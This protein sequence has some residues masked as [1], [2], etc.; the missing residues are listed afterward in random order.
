MLVWL[1]TLLKHMLGFCT[2]VLEDQVASP[3]SVGQKAFQA[4]PAMVFTVQTFLAEMVATEELV[5]ARNGQDPSFLQA[6]GTQLQHK[7]DHMAALSH[8]DAVVLFQALANS[9]L[10]EEVTTTLTKTVETKLIQGGGNQASKTTMQAQELE[11]LQNYLTPSDWAKLED[12]TMF[13]GVDTVVARLRSLGCTNAKECTKKATVGLLLA[14]HLQKSPKMPPYSTIYELSNHFGQMLSSSTV[15]V[16]DGVPSLQVYPQHPSAL[17]QSML[18]KIYGAE[19]PEARL[20]ERLPLLLAHHIPVRSSSK[21]LKGTMYDPSAKNQQPKLQEL[22]QPQLQLAQLQQPQLQLAQL[23]HPAAAPTAGDHSAELPTGTCQLR[24]STSLAA[25]FAAVGQPDTT[26]AE[27]ARA[28]T[29]RLTLASNC[30]CSR[31]KPDSC[32][33]GRPGSRR[34]KWAGEQSPRPGSLDHSGHA[35]TPSQQE[36]QD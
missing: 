10:P 9:Q 16:P 34:A 25:K 14:M 24:Y 26:A 20:L 33:R 15:H 2:A 32:S 36:S 21:L 29:A 13:Q 19:M 22:Q 30:S 23:Q 1:L 6:M 5:K 17:G 12:T 18:Q 7:L 3:S 27:A 28:T 35:A 11:H 4:L 8:Q 31:A